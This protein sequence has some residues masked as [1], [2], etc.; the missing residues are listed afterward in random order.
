MGATAASIHDP[1][2]PRPPGGM[3]AGALL[4][5]AVHGLLV[6]ALAAGVRWRHE[7]PQVFSAELWAALP[8][9]AA[10]RPVEPEPAPPAAAQTPPKPAVE[11]AP[12]P[13]TA[14]PTEAEIAIERAEREQER[15]RREQE[16]LAREQA[17]A[18]KIERERAAEAERLRKAEADLLRKQR[19]LQQ[20]REAELKRKAE[21]ARLER[22][23]KAAEARLEAQRQE[24]L[25]RMLGQAGATGSANAKGSAER[26]AGASA[27]YAGKLRAHILPHVVWTDPLPPVRAAEVEVRSSPTGRVLTRRIV[28]SSGNTAWDE[29]VLR[30]VDRAGTLPAD[31]DG[32][33]PSSI[34]ISFSPE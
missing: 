33:V 16:Q 18:A 1:L 13:P 14:V 15:K 21:Q 5:L 34:V 10:P 23:R 9:Q 29:A 8:Q 28:R 12:P 26:D 24:N 22:E 27:T 25:K 31:T 17:R 7:T 3:G 20:R 30:A 6:I 32:R 11:A 2:L 19:E 4:A